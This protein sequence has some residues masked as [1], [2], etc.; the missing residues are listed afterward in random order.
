[1][2]GIS[3]LGVLVAIYWIGFVGYRLG[4][5]D[6]D[7]WYAHHAPSTCVTYPVQ[8]EMGRT[9]PYPNIGPVILYAID[10]KTCQCGYTDANSEGHMFKASCDAG[11]IK[12]IQ[13]IKVRTTE[14]VASIDSEEAL[15]GA[16]SGAFVQV[17]SD[18]CDGKL[19]QKIVDSHKP[20]VASVEEPQ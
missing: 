11:K 1:M 14:P 13:P 6:A 19:S 5:G 3:L 7:H 17:L 4:K 9:K 20:P 10:A 12:L 15:K 16:T 18:P 8:N 2:K